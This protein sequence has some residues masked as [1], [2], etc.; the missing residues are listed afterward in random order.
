MP[1]DM[2]IELQSWKGDKIF[3]NFLWEGRYIGFDTHMQ[4]RSWRKAKRVSY[5][6]RQKDSCT[7]LAIYVVIMIKSAY[8]IH[9]RNVIYAI[10]VLS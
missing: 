1:D 9:Y 6:Q 10:E 7:C 4:N 3:Y 2:S 8:L 5:L